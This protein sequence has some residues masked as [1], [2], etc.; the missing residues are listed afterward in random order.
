MMCPIILVILVLSE[1]APL[2]P[3]KKTHI[4]K[5]AAITASY[6]VR[7]PLL[8]LVMLYTCFVI[9]YCVYMFNIS[10]IKN[11]KYMFLLCTIILQS[12]LL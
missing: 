6:L 12:N 7:L 10:R 4:F 5:K 8:D 11:A 3:P 2:P 1:Y 9:I